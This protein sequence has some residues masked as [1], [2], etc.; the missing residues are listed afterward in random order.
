MGGVRWGEVRWEVVVVGE[1]VGRSGWGGEV[2]MCRGGVGG[3]RERFFVGQES[4]CFRKSVIFKQND[5]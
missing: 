2:G 4:L 3:R 1:V 5:F